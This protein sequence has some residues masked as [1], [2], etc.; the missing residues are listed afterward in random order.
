MRMLQGAIWTRF[1]GQKSIYCTPYNSQCTSHSLR[2]FPCWLTKNGRCLGCVIYSLRTRIFE[3]FVHC[4]L[5]TGPQITNKCLEDI[6]PRH[7]NILCRIC[8][9]RV[10]AAYR[11]WFHN[12]SGDYKV[13]VHLVYSL[14]AVCCI[15]CD[16]TPSCYYCHLPGE[17]QVLYDIPFSGTLQTSW[18]ARTETENR[19]PLPPA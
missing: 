16:S 6:L 18:S 1:M 10:A 9:I 17:M 15:P 2:Q 4:D 8:S 12:H 3:G 19:T 5:T 11:R 13:Y 7:S 14:T